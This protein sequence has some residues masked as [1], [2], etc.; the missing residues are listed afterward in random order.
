MHAMTATAATVR[1]NLRN[2]DIVSSLNS[3]TLPDARTVR[4][5]Q[6]GIAEAMTVQHF[7]S[8]EA[9]RIRI[10][11][12]TV[13]YILRCDRNSTHV[14]KKRVKPTAGCDLRHGH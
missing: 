3:K 7:C 8:G 9:K 6:L 2:R 1:N 13:N 10:S 11:Q 5:F 14:E 12:P 4:Q